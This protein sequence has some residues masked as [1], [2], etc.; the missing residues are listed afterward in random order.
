M[1]VLE[2]RTDHAPPNIDFLRG[3]KAQEVNLIFAAGKPRRF[4]ARSVMTRQGEPASHLLLLWRGTARY[5]LETQNGKK[6][7]LMP[8]T[9][10][11]FFGGAALVSGSATYL[12]SS[13]AVKDSTVLVWE[14][15]TIRAF[16]RRFHLLLENALFIALDHF[17][18]YVSAYSS[19]SSKTARE[20]LAHVLVE[21]APAIGQKLLDGIELDI[22]NEELANSANVT[23]YTASRMVSQWEKIGALH[24]QRGK[25][26]LRA[27]ER[28]FLRA[29]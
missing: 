9:P 29:L 12:V 7:N 25:I 5:L 2:F 15:A 26:L 28:L 17:S 21:L 20:R 16:A 13:E 27:P 19:L 1:T 8:I 4:S 3:L 14:G 23:P 22:T 24:K 10:G 18:W 11:H 6:L